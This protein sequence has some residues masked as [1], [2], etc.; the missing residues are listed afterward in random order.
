MDRP[1]HI[2][3]DIYTAQ[4]RLRAISSSGA[5]VTL[6]DGKQYI[7]LMNGKG[8]VTLGHHHP[9]V[10]SAIAHHL[11]GG[12]A[13]A[14]C[15]SNLHE[16]L[17]N[18]IIGDVEM[19]EAQLALFSTGTEACRAAVQVARQFTGR[20][21][22][23]SAGY[24]GWGDYWAN[25]DHLLEANAS[26]VIDFY[27]VPE[28]LEQLLEQHRGQTA[29]VILSPDYIHLQPDTLRRLAQIAKHEGVLLCCDDVK[30]GYRSMRASKF[31]G[32]VGFHADLYTFAKG[33]ANGHRLSCLV[34]RSDVM[35]AAKEFTYTAY[36]DTIPI[37]A[38]LATLDYMDNHDGYQRLVQCGATLAA[39]MRNIVR[40]SELPIEIFGDGPMLQIVGATEALDQTLYTNFAM[41]GLLLYEGDNQTVSLAT[42]DV[43]DELLDRFEKGLT[44]TSQCFGRSYPASISPQRRFQAAFRM[45]DGANDVVP[46]EEAIRWIK[47]ER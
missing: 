40:R 12:L 41:A 27:F 37:V 22:I 4:P 32:T 17:T 42:S 1:H 45:I 29:L 16:T 9:A 6:S 35:A 34:G 33:L 14:T 7:D 43:L 25:S 15:W 47:E 39:E 5:K 36:F 2:V 20:H 18:R 8:S 46:V 38:A 13:S 24:H 19:D 26:G 11:H 31:P 30:Q 21:V 10:N 28:L 23:A 3:T 44:A